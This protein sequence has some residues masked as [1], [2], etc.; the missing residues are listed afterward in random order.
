MPAR[1]KLTIRRA[2]V[3]DRAFSN[4]TQ[5]TRDSTN[6]LFELVVESFA[7]VCTMTTLYY[8]V[9]PI[10]TTV[11]ASNSISAIP[12]GIGYTCREHCGLWLKGA[13]G[14]DTSGCGLTS[15]IN[16]F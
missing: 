6:I 15:S 5:L 7:T 10:S 13:S 2:G 4:S 12:G 3:H 16:S 14:Y 8:N 9:S 11:V 1:E